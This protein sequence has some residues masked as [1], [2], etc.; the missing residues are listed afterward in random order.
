MQFAGRRPGRLEQRLVAPAR[1][2]ARRAERTVGGDFCAPQFGAVPGHVGVIPGEPRERARIG[3]QHGRREEVVAAGERVSRAAREVDAHEAVDGFGAARAVIFHDRDEAPVRGVDDRV[4]I[5]DVGG[6]GQRFG[7]TA[8]LEPVEAL[9]GE[10]AEEGAARVIDREGAPAV[11]MGERAHV[12]GGRDEVFDT[13]VGVV[14]D[15]DVAA[16][17]LRAALG[18]EDRRPADRGL[19]E[20]DRCADDQLRGDRG[21]PTAERCAHT[22]VRGG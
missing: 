22:C 14:F 13:A 11:F 4:G 2:L 15:E 18:P 8:R 6:L 10:V 16:L 12:V 19:A 7:L 5:A 3:A 21:F 1:D 17:F 20:P 9:V